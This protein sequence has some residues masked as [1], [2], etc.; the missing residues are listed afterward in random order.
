[1]KK[2]TRKKE[3]PW[4]GLEPTA[5]CCLGRVLYHLRYLGSRDG[6]VLQSKA[7]LKSLCVKHKNVITRAGRD[8]TA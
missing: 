4:V 6:R 1:V 8:E 2:L 5:D 3:L 7:N